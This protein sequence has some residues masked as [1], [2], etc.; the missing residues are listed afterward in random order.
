ME[1][2]LARAPSI[3]PG[4]SAAARWHS[5]AAHRHRLHI[6]RGPL[7]ILS[8]L[9]VRIAIDRRELEPAVD[10]L[11]EPAGGVVPAR[12]Q[13]LVSSRDLDEDCDV[14]AGRDRHPYHRYADSE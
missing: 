14:P 13:Q 12:S 3:A 4:F 5:G 6:R 11:D 7:Q 2:C 1:S 10:A 9:D 8:R